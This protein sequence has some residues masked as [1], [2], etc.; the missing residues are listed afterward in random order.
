M[1]HILGITE[2]KIF[3]APEEE[4]ERER[5]KSES[6]LCYVFVSVFIKR[7]EAAGSKNRSGIIGKKRFTFHLAELKLYP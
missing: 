5:N 2:T 1:V 7:K 3:K 4:E 6:D